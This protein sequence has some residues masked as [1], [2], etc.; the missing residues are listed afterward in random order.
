MMISMTA[1]RNLDRTYTLRMTIRLEYVT[2]IRPIG[3]FK[4]DTQETREKIL[5]AGG[6]WVAD[7]EDWV[8]PESA[9]EPLRASRIFIVII[10]GYCCAPVSPAEV[11]EHELK[12]G[13]VFRVY[14]P[15]CGKR[16]PS[17]TLWEVPI[18][19][20]CGEGEEGQRTYEAAFQ[21]EIE[22]R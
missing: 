16:S 21:N 14:C 13:K 2:E 12:R 20:F 6:R 19:E 8:V 17:S 7:L 3:W 4:S 10:A 18:V 15:R 1:W 11:R 5:E 9:L 22:G